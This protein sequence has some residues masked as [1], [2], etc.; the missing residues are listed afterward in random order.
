MRRKRTMA[1]VV[2]TNS[3]IDATDADTHF[4]HALHAASW[5]SASPSTKDSALVTATRMIDR[6]QWRGSKTSESQTLLWPRSGVTYP[7]GDAVDSVSVP[8]FILDATCEL[9]LA[10]IEDIEVQSNSST[11]SN[12]S[13][14]KAGSA[15]IEYFSSVQHGT[16]FPTIVHE[17]L[18]F[19]LA[20][21]LLSAPF[22]SGTDVLTGLDDYGLDG[23]FDA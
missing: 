23:G 9:A 10:L 22:S 1:L 11:G 5:T 7:D 8:Q 16:R 15:E 19:F 2:G 6:Q 3:Y 21:S 17:L 14:L 13:R 18:R 4:L 20:G 12:I